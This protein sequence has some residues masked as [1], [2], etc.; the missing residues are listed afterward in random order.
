MNTITTALLVIALLTYV[1]YA[2][3]TARGIYVDGQSNVIDYDTPYPYQSYDNQLYEQ[4][5]NGASHN[6][7]LCDC[8][9][10]NKGVYDIN[11]NDAG[12]S[13][14][15]GHHEQSNRRQ[16]HEHEHKHYQHGQFHDTPFYFHRHGNA[17]FYPPIAVLG[18]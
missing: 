6:V 15:N 7:R 9:L 4:Q 16:H 12:H 2:S 18:G 17:H 1:M 14:S 5:Y 8:G 13:H 3:S 10:D 11:N